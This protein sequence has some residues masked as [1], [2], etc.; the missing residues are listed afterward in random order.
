MS[1]WGGPARRHE[2]TPDAARVNWGARG[3]AVVDAGRYPLVRAVED[4]GVDFELHENPDGTYTVHIR[5]GLPFG[6]EAAAMLSELAY[7]RHDHCPVCTAVIL[8]SAGLNPGTES[9]LADL[10]RRAVHHNWHLTHGPER[11]P[12]PRA[13]SAGTT[14]DVERRVS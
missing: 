4:L 7:Q 1:T 3:E 9:E 8:K 12:E 2:G 14:P 13:D 10:I 5:H 6:H 11:R